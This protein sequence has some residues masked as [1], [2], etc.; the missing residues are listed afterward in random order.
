[1]CESRG[2]LLVPKVAL[3]SRILP[4]FRRKRR[5]LGAGPSQLII[6]KRRIKTNENMETKHELIISE[7]ILITF[8]I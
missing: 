3:V 4:P 6:K 2:N 1:M 5:I 7:K 8:G